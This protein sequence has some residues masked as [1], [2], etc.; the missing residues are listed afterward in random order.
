MTAHTRMPPKGRERGCVYRVLDKTIAVYMGT[1][2]RLTVDAN[3]VMDAVH[4]HVYI[5]V[6]PYL[7]RGT[8]AQRLARETLT[9]VDGQTGEYVCERVVQDYLPVEICL[10][11]VTDLGLHVDMTTQRFTVP[12][13]L[14]QFEGKRQVVYVLMD[15]NQN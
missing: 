14:Y 15:D 13:T 9:L 2:T 8:P 4:G 5:G 10:G 3:G 6:S 11:R 12:N 1:G 7:A